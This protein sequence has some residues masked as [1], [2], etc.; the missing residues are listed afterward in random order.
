MI[1]ETGMNGP[2]GR[3][4]FALY[5]LCER[6]AADEGT[7]S[8]ATLLICNPCVLPPHKMGHPQPGSRRDCGESRIIFVPIS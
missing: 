1:Y 7:S 8:D 2:L 5:R 3:G 4:R 6:Q